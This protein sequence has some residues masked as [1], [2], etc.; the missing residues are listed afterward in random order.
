MIRSRA[1]LKR[2][3]LIIKAEVLADEILEEQTVGYVKEWNINGETGDSWRR[4]NARMESLRW[5]EKTEIL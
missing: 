2:M 5:Q 3:R 1:Y 4:R